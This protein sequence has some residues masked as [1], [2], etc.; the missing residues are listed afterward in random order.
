[1]L[2]ES[3]AQNSKM[4]YLNVQLAGLSGRPHP[5]L[6]NILTTQ[7][8]KKLRVHLKFLTCDYLTNERLSKERPGISS[9]CD[10]CLGNPDTIEHILTSCTA[11]AD[12]RSRLYPELVNTVT[13]VQPMCSIL[14][15]HPS[16]SILTQFILD[17]T[18]PNLPVSYRVPAHNPD[19]YKICKI[20]R[21]WCFA[22]SSERSRLLKNLDK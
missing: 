11:T 4:K 12:I 21:D 1:M 20:S 10:L 16:P 14:L 3:A 7:D 18:S 15:H 8:A 5:V 17:C 6:H 19:T 13:Q 2:R 9:A 22:I